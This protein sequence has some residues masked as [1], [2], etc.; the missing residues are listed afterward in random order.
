MARKLDR[1]MALQSDKQA[2]E[3]Q[4]QIKQYKELSNQTPEVC[5]D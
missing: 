2:K 5:Q 4:T 1:L 3:H